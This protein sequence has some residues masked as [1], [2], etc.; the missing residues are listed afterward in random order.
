LLH[1]TYSAFEQSKSECC[2]DLNLNEKDIKNIKILIRS[3]NVMNGSKSVRNLTQGKISSQIL[4][5]AI[6]V[7][8][9]N[10][11]QELYNVVDTLIVGQTLGEIK[12]AAVG[13]T[14]STFLR[15]DFS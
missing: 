2:K 4:F 14:S 5:F 6:P 10:L 13:S 15:S 3:V 1:T 11:L 9:G 12:L 8:I 7:I